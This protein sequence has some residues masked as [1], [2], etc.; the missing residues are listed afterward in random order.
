[1][2]LLI[3]FLALLATFYYT[4]HLFLKHTKNEP[5]SPPPGPK[6]LPIIG[7]LRRF[8]FSSPHTCLADLARTY[9]PIISLQFGRTSVVVV[10]S[11]ELAKE[12]LKTQDLNFCTRPPMVGPKK[13][14]YEGLDIAFCPYNDYFREI[15]KIS[16][17]HLLNSKRVQSFGPIRKE[18]IS[19]LLDKIS[20]LS[21]ASQIVNLSELVMGFSCSN[22]CRMAFGKRYNDDEEGRSKFYNLVNK[23]QASFMSS[24]FEQYFPSIGWLDKLCGQSSRLQTTFK[25]FDAFYQQIIDHHLNPTRPKP[26]QDDIIDVLLHLQKQRC[27]PFDL[28]MNHIKALLINIIVAGTDTSAVMIIWAMTQ[29]IKNPSTM[30]KVQEEIR[31][32]TKNINYIDDEQ[33]QTLDYFKA[34]VK[35]TFRLHPAAPLLIA[36]ESTQKTRIKGDDILPKTLVYVNAWAI[37]RDPKSWNDP[38]KFMPERFIGSSIDVRGNDFEMIPFGAGRRM[39]P[40]LQLGLANME[41]PL[42]NLLK[43][44]NWDLPVGVKREQIDLDTLPGILANK[45]NPLCLVAQKF[46]GLL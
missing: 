43:C 26:D 31:N 1:M 41:I 12:V 10:Q 34:V 23:G 38:E 21:F 35:E 45:K 28:S 40:G 29:L 22:I 18:E 33:V 11:A 32:A 9:G 7:N 36:H 14:S 17:V 42:A 25:A 3:Y 4:Y 13:L 46:I 20:S 30:K 19:R 16:I 39:C 27:F 44:Y 8:D 24:Y 5:Y 6:R 2:L 37:G 15:K